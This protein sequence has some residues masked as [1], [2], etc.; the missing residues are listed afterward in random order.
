MEVLKTQ[1]LAV[2]LFKIQTC[3]NARRNII[4]YKLFFGRM[5]ISHISHTEC[6][7]WLSVL[8]FRCCMVSHRCQTG[9]AIGSLH[10]KQMKHF[11]LKVLPAAALYSSG[12][13]L[14]CISSIFL[15]QGFNIPKLAEFTL[16]HFQFFF[17]TTWNNVLW[18]W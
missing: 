15:N 12:N 8:E 3:A 14:L 5:C 11:E 2:W 7:L 17:K 13:N 4:N 9:A 10:T 6:R 18:L 1:R 16:C